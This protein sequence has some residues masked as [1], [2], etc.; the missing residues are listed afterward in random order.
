MQDKKV[1]HTTRHLEISFFLF[2]SENRHW[3]FMQIDPKKTIRMKCQSFFLGKIIKNIF[4][5]SFAEFA[6][7]VVKINS[8]HS[9]IVIFYSR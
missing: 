7:K 4:K 2:L 5:M 1:Q 9:N 3:H 6:R 8:F